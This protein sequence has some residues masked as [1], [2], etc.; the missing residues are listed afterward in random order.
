MDENSIKNQENTY[1]FLTNH[2]LG[3][4]LF[5]NKSQD[6]IATVISEKIINEKDFK[7]IGIDG[8]WGSGKSNLVH[9][10]EKKVEKTHKFFIYDVWGHQ[11]DEQRRAILVE[12]TEFIKNEK[13]LLKKNEKDFWDDQLKI[14]LANSKETVTINQPYLSVGFIFSLLSIIYIPTVNV[15]KD[16]LRDF[17]DIESWFWKLVLV[18]FPLFIVVGIYIYNLYRNWID[19]KGFIRSFRLSAEETF[20]VYTNKQK[21][22][23]K[24]E[25]ISENQPSVR[26]F[27]KWMKEIDDDLNKKIVLVFD[28]FDRLPKKHI[29][30]IW[31]SIHIFFAEKEYNNIKVILPFDREHIQNAFKELNSDGT[32]K[33]FGDDYVNKTF[34]I[35][36]RV[37]LPIMSDWKQFFQNQWSKAFTNYD[38][39][40][41]R[42]V[43]QTYEFLSKRITPRE[44][45][46]FINEILTIKLLD[47][48]FKERYIAIFVLKKDEILISPLKSITEFD[49][50]DGLKSIYYTDPDF[51]KQL[52]A[53]IYHIQVE[54]AVELIYTQEL[55][56]SL[57]KYDVDKF[58]SICNSDFADSFFSSTIVDIDVL[59]NPIKTLSKIEDGTKITKLQIDQAWK[60]LF[61]KVLNS[62]PIV[63]KLEIEDWQ[64]IIIENYKD[65]QYLKLL[66]NQYIELVNESNTMEYVVLVDKLIDHLEE[67]KVLLLLTN[68]NLSAK[69]FI[70]LTEDK[71]SAY[72]KYKLSCDVKTLD[73]YLSKILIDDILVL[74]KTDVL[75]EDFELPTFVKH[76]KENFATAVDQNDI[77][78]S[79][80]ILLKIKEATKEE[81]PPLKD[82]LQD[83]KIYTLYTSNSS[84][85]SPIINDLVA[86]RIAK[87]SK[88][89]SSYRSYF[90]NILES[91]DISRAADI[92]TKIL[93]YISYDDLLM[94][95]DYFE[96]LILF[97]QMILS[98]F[99]NSNL[100][101]KSNISNLINKYQ[102]IKNSL[103]LD[104]D[105]LIKE[106]NRWKVEDSKLILENL[107]DRFIEDCFKYNDLRIS[108]SFIDKFN[109]SFHNLDQEG[110]KKIFDTD[111]NIHFKYFEFLNDESLTQSSIDAFTA[112]FLLRLSN[113]QAD[114]QWWK[115]LYKYEA[116]N[117]QLSVVNA[118]KDIRDQFLNSH[119][120]INLETAKKILPYFIK[121]N[122]LEPSTDVFRTIIK[123]SFLSDVMFK[124]ILLENV[125]FVKD[126][127]QMTSQA[128]KDG[129][130]N[131]I[132]ERRDSD[133]M[134]EQL[135]KQIGIR[136]T[137]EQS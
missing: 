134:S 91:D 81:N 27:Q 120:E 14:L 7:I 61:Y 132:N 15:F 121:Y 113:G 55:K 2:P 89:N 60:T 40:E 42:L 28:N 96:D 66:L 37:T 118:L 129:F 85:S 5:K 1:N 26:D 44:I 20:Q 124:E 119:I 30:N 83:A 127:Y 11:E 23:T 46:A 12:L 135:A 59:E 107:D 111:S 54:E 53:I 70:E 13:D 69:N 92:G 71:G 35:V 114:D 131:I 17:F 67:D 86:M 106:L 80:D 4:D 126:L 31:S 47:E 9:L 56:D 104:D 32:N 133:E 34:D 52:T 99:S 108:K 100:I 73:N 45:I 36:F 98:M 105:K 29:L 39:E 82:L 110:T 125:S 62:N 21:E 93:S 65:D 128:Q 3:E 116:N 68:K 79:N 43:T 78:K 102:D 103:K 84:S 137:K 87:G 77:Q 115:I 18:A 72:K 19:K 25:T 97:K 112:Q 90:Q 95:S 49:Y 136:K 6:K 122:L 94:N 64:L 51:A 10:I 117:S 101:K 16:S 57:N 48:N 38:K 50:L 63:E 58:N 88:F 109:L 130:R 24:I 75:Y 8:A 33:T 123:N 76:L 22:E 74:N 41:L